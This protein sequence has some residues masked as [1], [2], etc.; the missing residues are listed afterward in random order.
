MD[1][2]LKATKS[3]CESVDY[4]G[5]LLLGA[6]GS[7]WSCVHQPRGEGGR[8]PQDPSLAW[9]AGSGLTRPPAAAHRQAGVAGRPQTGHS[10]GCLRLSSIPD[11]STAY[12]QFTA[13]PYYCP[14]TWKDYTEGSNV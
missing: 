5:T 10:T 8:P 12:L 13:R 14:C 3:Q 9:V 4:L 11:H 2:N 6:C 1:T 7:E